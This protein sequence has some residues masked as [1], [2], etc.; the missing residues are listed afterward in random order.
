METNDKEM[1][2][3]YEDLPEVEK[4]S[5]IEFH[6]NAYK[7]DLKHTEKDLMEFPRWSIIS[8]YYAMHNIT[9]LYLGKNHNVKIVGENIHSKTLKA[10]SKFIQNKQEKEKVIRLLKKAE[11]SF[12]NI[13]R[14]EEKTLPLMLR[15]GKTE[16]GKTQYYSKDFS[17]INSQRSVYFLDN[18]VKPYIKIMEG[19]LSLAEEK[20]GN[21]KNVA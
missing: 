15:K 17:D 19:M 2:Q 3:L 6:E 4:E 9:K 10:L 13:L 20:K 21:N 12:F 8:G 14:L 7:D 1:P 16:R 18:I 11:I 5:W